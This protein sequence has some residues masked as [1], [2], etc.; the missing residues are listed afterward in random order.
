MK[1]QGCHGMY[2]T[3]EAGGILF[4]H[5]TEINMTC[6][7][8]SHEWIRGRGIKSIFFLN[9]KLNLKL[10]NLPVPADFAPAETSN[11]FLVDRIRNRNGTTGRKTGTRSVENGRGLIT[12]TRTAR[13]AFQ[14]MNWWN[15]R[16]V[17]GT[18]VGTL[19]SEVRE[20]LQPKR[21]AI[22]GA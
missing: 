21:L 7:T 5:E 20:Y 13:R 9:L 22:P 1:T 2:R 11:W 16:G 18:E 17:D 6:T 3:G 10:S 15:A 14:L 4:T 19:P 12:M 8:G